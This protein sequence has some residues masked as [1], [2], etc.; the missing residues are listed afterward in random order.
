MECEYS[1]V[2]MVL[3]SFVCAWNPDDS[4]FFFNSGKS[5]KREQSGSFWGIFCILVKVLGLLFAFIDLLC[6]I[7]K[8]IEG[9]ESLVSGLLPS[10][11]SQRWEDI[12]HLHIWSGI[13]DGIW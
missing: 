2:W 4:F 11:V 12:L 8:L 13:K 5:L 3:A 7:A 6:A 10:E 1:E 9:S